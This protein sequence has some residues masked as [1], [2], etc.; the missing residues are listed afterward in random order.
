MGVAA[1]EDAKDSPLSFVHIVRDNHTKVSRVHARSE[2]EKVGK[3]ERNRE[4][5]FEIHKDYEESG[6]SDDEYEFE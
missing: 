1:K 4:N 2:S 3:V 5:N 6:S